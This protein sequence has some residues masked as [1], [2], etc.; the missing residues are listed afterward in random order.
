MPVRDP[1][2]GKV[3]SYLR[4][5]Y[6]DNSVYVRC[7]HHSNCST[8]KTLNFDPKNPAQSRPFGFLGAWALRAFR[9][10]D[11]GAHKGYIPSRR[12]RRRVRKQ[13]H[14]EED[15]AWYFEMEGAALSES[16]PERVT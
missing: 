7:P 5:D 3:V 8:T 2:T 16:E 4:W 12:L 9:F 15:S 6:T 1:A 14:A 10:E 11:K 13:M